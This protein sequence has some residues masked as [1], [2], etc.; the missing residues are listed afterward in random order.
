MSREIRN[1]RVA[2]ALSGAILLVLALGC[3]RPPGV[4]DSP[5]GET[6]K[7]PFDR[8]PRSGGISPSQSA[9][10][11]SVRVP[12]GTSLAVRLRDPLS[13]ASAQ[14]GDRFDG[15]IDEPVADEGQTVI[16]KG[17]PVS[18]R[19]LEARPAGGSH[20]PGYLRITL[21]SVEIGGRTVLIDT[22]S[23]FT[24]AGA[25]EGKTAAIHPETNE[26]R[27]IVLSPDR[28]LTFR[29]AQAIELK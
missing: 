5:T 16:M 19:V 2:V 1:G 28:R 24:K 15:T 4:P 8:T 22:S 27:E 18:G 23:I 9:I 14:P 21:V 29:L 20:A 25:H 10:P 26:H 7:L 13:S 11:A 3:G 17:A 12:E 6:Q